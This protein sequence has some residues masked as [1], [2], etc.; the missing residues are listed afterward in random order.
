MQGILRGYQV[1]QDGAKRIKVDISPEYVQAV[2]AIQ[3]EMRHLLARKGIA[4]EAAPTSNVLI[5]TFRKYE[6]HPILTFFNRGLPVTPQ[7][8]AACAQLQ[9]S[10]NTDDSGVFYT[11]L[12]MEHALLA[13]GIERLVGEDGKL[14]FQ[15]TDIYNWLDHIRVMGNDQ[16]FQ[17]TEP[18]PVD[19]TGKGG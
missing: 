19:V 16:S 1:R 15:R 3:V 12:E 8:E 11:N 7:E 13:R 4:V 9:V 17:E 14:R 2:K 10:I 18:V 6:D 5:G